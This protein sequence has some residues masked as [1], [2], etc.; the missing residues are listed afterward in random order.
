MDAP[1]TALQLDPHALRVLAHPL[2]SRLLTALRMRG[3]ATATSL[4]RQLGTNTGATSYHLRKLG[5]VGLVEETDEGRGR[6]RWWRA[7][8]AGHGWKERDIAGDPDA[9]AASDWLKRHY[10]RH[11]AERYERWLETAK[12]EPLDWRDAADSGDAELRVSPD[13]LREFETELLA[14]IDRYRSTSPADPDARRVAVYYYTFPVTDADSD[15]SG[16]PAE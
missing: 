7:S 9:E 5:S 13:R 2:R 15:G 8:T 16:E 10:L 1:F 3:P 14:L 12:D 4:A 11:F 6:E